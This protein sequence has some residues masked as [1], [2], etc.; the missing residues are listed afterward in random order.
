MIC[1]KWKLNNY[2]KY[3]HNQ[4]YEGFLQSSLPVWYRNAPFF[5]SIMFYSTQKYHFQEAEIR[6]SFSVW[7]DHHF[8]PRAILMSSLL[9]NDGHPTGNLRCHPYR[10]IIAKRHTKTRSFS[11]TKVINS[12]SCNYSVRTEVYMLPIFYLNFH[13]PANVAFVTMNVARKLIRHSTVK[14]CNFVWSF[15]WQVYPYIKLLCLCCSS[16]D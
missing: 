3:Y 6:R 9:E 4:F 8:Q 14:F 5:Q 12:C 16:T 10:K 15:L 7:N 1:S 11:D 13:F 2:E